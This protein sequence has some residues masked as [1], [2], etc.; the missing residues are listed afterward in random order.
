[1][2]IPLLANG[3]IGELKKFQ[4]RDTLLSGQGPRSFGE[5][6]KHRDNGWF[7]SGENLIHPMTTEEQQNIDTIL[8]NPDTDPNSTS[9]TVSEAHTA[10]EYYLFANSTDH[11][12]ELSSTALAHLYFLKVQNKPAEYNQM[13]VDEQRTWNLSK[14]KTIRKYKKRRHITVAHSEEFRDLM[15]RYLRGLHKLFLAHQLIPYHHISIHLTELLSHFGLTTAWCCWV[16]ERYNHMLQNIESNGRFGELKKTLFERMCMIQRL[17]GLISSFE[18]GHCLQPLADQLGIY[19]SP[20]VKG[21]IFKDL[22]G[23]DAQRDALQGEECWLEQEVLTCLTELLVCSRKASHESTT[24]P[25]KARQY[26]KFSHRGAMF[27]P[28][29]FSIRD[30][31]VIIGHQISSDWH[32]GKIKQ[33]FTVPFRL[34]SE[35][36][37]IVQRFKELSAQEAQR[38]PYRRYPFV[39]GRLYDPELEGE[40]EVVAVQEVIAHFA[41]T[42]YDGQAFG[43]PCFHALPLDKYY[44]DSRGKGHSIRSTAAP[45]E[46]PPTHCLVDFVAMPPLTGNLAMSIWLDLLPIGATVGTCRLYEAVNPNFD[47]VGLGKRKTGQGGSAIP[48]QYPTREA[49]KQVA[50]DHPSRATV[51]LTLRSCCISTSHFPLSL[52]LGDAAPDPR[53]GNVKAIILVKLLS[54]GWRLWIGALPGRGDVELLLVL[55]KGPMTASLGT[56]KLQTKVEGY[57]L[58]DDSLAKTLTGADNVLAF[59]TSQE[60]LSSWYRYKCGLGVRS[61]DRNLFAAREQLHYFSKKKK[62]KENAAKNNERTKAKRVKNEEASTKPKL[63][64]DPSEQPYCLPPLVLVLVLEGLL[65]GLGDVFLDYRV[66]LVGPPIHDLRAEVCIEYRTCVVLDPALLE[67]VSEMVHRCLSKVGL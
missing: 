9:I 51:W 2:S 19:L 44:M 52:F 36:Y 33:I 10:M 46:Q 63:M 16:F 41:C 23:V 26:N 38:D 18:L 25:G 65:D 20:T 1:M 50:Q 4:G 58:P 28:S 3:N 21:T 55:G 61:H 13:N 40:I 7:D 64:E 42:P 54:E 47:S 27:S 56:T 15:L 48:M 11:F 62:K 8:A 29:L 30:S 6:Q 60:M 17:R 34:S 49:M 14:M 37:F 45:H 59:P 22:S 32:T 5:G 57:L 67:R 12:L 35:A 53:P 24:M 66:L 39:G 31:H 43:I